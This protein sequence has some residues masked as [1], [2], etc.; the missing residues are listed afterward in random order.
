MSISKTLKA[1]FLKSL[2]KKTLNDFDIQ[3]SSKV[4]M[5]RYDRIGDMIITTPVFREFK[6]SFPDAELNVLASRS[7]SIILKN[8]PHVDNI[9]INDKNNLLTD[10]PVLLKLRKKQID[11][12]IEF[13]HSVV[14]HAIIRLIIIKPKKIISVRKDGRYGVNGDELEMYDFYTKKLPDTH[15]RDIWLATLIPFGI[16]N[17]SYSYDIYID[18]NDEKDA[19]NFLKQYKN[20]FLIGINL[21]GAVKGKI[22]K[23]KELEII[24]KDIYDFNTNIQIIIIHTPKKRDEVKYEIDKMNLNYVDISFPTDNIIIASSLIK[25]LDL[26]ITPDTSIV[27]VASC[28][29]KPVISIHEDNIESYKLFAPTSDLNRTI[30][31]KTNNS[32]IGFSTDLVVNASRELIDELTKYEN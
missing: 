19:L 12:C 20:K 30:F 3:K 9:F 10:L 6:S 31:S 27:H 24:C 29:N 13:D 16:K 7:N 21:E 4:L 17:V 25:N 2:T 32:L 23:Y 11:V 1:F 28:F 5:L 26:I 14:R 8:N 18:K 22:I 15:F